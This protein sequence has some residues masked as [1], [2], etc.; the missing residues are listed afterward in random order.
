MKSA[1]RVR[2]VVVD[3]DGTLLDPSKQISP[4]DKL[5]IRALHSQGVHFAIATGRRFSAVKAHLAELDLVEEPWVV[6]NSGA[7]IKRG[8]HGALA[9]RRL[10]DRELARRALSVASGFDAG[11][12]V[13]DGPDAESHLLVDRSVN[14]EPLK[15]YLRTT[16]PEPTGLASLK[17]ARDP[18]QLTFAATISTN[19]KLE[20][21]LVEDL[22]DGLATLRTEY[23][24]PEELSLLDVTHPQA[25]K[26]AAVGWLIDELR[27]GVEAL[28]VIGDNWNDLDMLELAAGGGQAVV[29]A[30]AVE[31]LRAR[32]ESTGSNE[33]SGVAQ[34]LEERVF[35]SDPLR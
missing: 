25:S 5:A 13:H 6:C 15:R 28:L 14:N 9:R 12:I 11:R 10:L 3:L 7:F 31:E 4:R 33:E 23:P 20:R 18:V 17:L 26:G 8:L 1:N 19:R 35:H 27:V 22:G 29:M 24:G 16:K 30:N 2:L 32:F 34:A 21:A